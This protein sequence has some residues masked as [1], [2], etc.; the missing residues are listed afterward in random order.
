MSEQQQMPDPEVLRAVVRYTAS[1]GDLDPG[2]IEV[3]DHPHQAEHLEALRLDLASQGEYFYNNLG[4]CL[5][6]IRRGEAYQAVSHDTLPAPKDIK[7]VQN[8]LATR[9]RQAVMNGLREAIGAVT[10]RDDCGVDGN[11]VGIRLDKAKLRGR[12][13]YLY[14]ET[15]LLPRQLQLVSRWGVCTEKDAKRLVQ[16]LTDV[17][18]HIFDLL[19]KREGSIRSRREMLDF[20]GLFV[21]LSLTDEG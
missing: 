2:K 15:A 19:A 13:V 4:K 7:T 10:L 18:W 21:S 9:V 8:S 3:M 14:E 12:M 16:P 1:W 20:I 5:R 17:D 6:A 11:L